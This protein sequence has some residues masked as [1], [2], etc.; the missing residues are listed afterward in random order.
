MALTESTMLPLGTQTPYFELPDT[1]SGKQVSLGDIAGETATVVVFLF[2]HCPYVLHINAELV[3]LATEYLPKGIGFVAISSNDAV[4]Y[5][6]DAPELMKIHAETVGYPFPYLYDETQAVARAFDAACTPDIFVFDA[7]SRLVY[8]GQLDASRPNNG[9]PVTGEAL[10]R[11]L[12]ALLDGVPI[13]EPQ[14]SSAGC[15]IKWR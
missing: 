6:Q 8:R 13:P 15:N 2:N 14:L 12:D 3:R 1:V 10:R 7:I 4:K 5:P 11:A 9:K